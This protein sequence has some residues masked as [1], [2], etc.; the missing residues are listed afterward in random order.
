MRK[1]VKN[2]LH[3]NS[4]INLSASKLP[5]ENIAVKKLNPPNPSLNK[6]LYKQIGSKYYWFDRLSWS[7]KQ[8]KEY[9]FKKNLFTYVMYVNNETAGFFELFYD[10]NKNE[11]EIVYLGILKEFF[12][13]KLGG[14]IL[15]EAIKISWSFKINR[16]WVHTCSLDHH[17]ALNNYLSRGMKIYKTETV[18]KDIPDSH[19]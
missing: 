8:W 3:I 9:V 2:F 6:F 14:Y 13:K 19:N 10:I 17:N 5:N 12:G 7:E 16:V 15:S 11:A 1:I 4:L 18:Y